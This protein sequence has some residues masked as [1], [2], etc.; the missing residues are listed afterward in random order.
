MKNNLIPVLAALLTWVGGDRTYSGPVESGF[1]YQGH[2]AVDALPANGLYELRFQLFDNLTAG[3]QVGGTIYAAPVPVRNGLFTVPLDFGGGVFNGDARWLEIGVRT[4]DS[5]AAHTVLVPRQNLTPQPYAIWALNAGSVADGA[6][7]SGKILSGQVVKSV[8]GLT[9]QVT[10]S[11]G[12]N[13]TLTPT[14]NDVQIS[15]DSPFR[16]RGN[17]PGGSGGRLVFGWPPSLSGETTY[18]SEEEENGLYLVASKGL[19]LG[20]GNVGI[21][22]ANLAE[23]LFP[24]T[25]GG[26]VLV[27]PQAGF[28][29]GTAS[30]LFLGDNNN[31]LRSVWGEGLRLGVFN[32]VD[33]L[34]LK[35]GGKVGMGTTNPQ[36]ALDVVSRGGDPQLRLEQTSAS[37]WARIRMGVSGGTKWDISV[38][39]GATPAMAFWNGSKNVVVMGHDGNVGIG[40]TPEVKLHVAGTTRTGVLQIT[41]GADVAEP[42]EVAS[43][44]AVPKGAVMVIDDQNPGQLRMSDRSFDKRVAG[45]VS[46]A[47]GLNPGLTLSQEGV[48][49][50]G[51]PVA[52]TGRVY[53]LV[54]ASHGPVRPGDHLTTSSTPGHAMKVTDYPSAQGAILGKAMSSLESGRGLVLVLVTLQ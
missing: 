35:N 13:I 29:P 16:L 25:V 30:S 15:V 19:G 54:D 8:N 46:G 33:A 34:T 43:A 12:A 9:D 27:R 4:N 41:G 5:F 3:S 49:A 17:G 44:G 2:L 24:L 42:F 23:A 28:G 50:Q 20:P 7:T 47:G 18:V 51:V 39:A 1:T 6:I 48:T 11:G 31:Y 52:L 45:V 36:G 37:D 38:G 21:H 10:L 26:D 14:G 40:T 32:G 22:L 53:T